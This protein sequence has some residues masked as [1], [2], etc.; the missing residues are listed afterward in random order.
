MMTPE[1]QRQLIEWGGERLSYCI[2]FGIVNFRN[3]G[4]TTIASTGSKIAPWKTLDDI[5][6]VLDVFG[7]KRKKPP[8]W[9][10]RHNAL[11]KSWYC[12]YNNEWR[13]TFPDHE[14]A[15]EYAAMMNAKEEQKCPTT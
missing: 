4:E 15:E 10:T 14:S 9:T 12:D 7:V 6:K 11:T 8:K 5:V 1:I 13:G 3:N 2:S